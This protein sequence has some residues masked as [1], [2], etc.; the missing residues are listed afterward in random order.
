MPRR[1]K[2][3]GCR[4][5]RGGRPERGWARS[6]ILAPAEKSIHIIKSTAAACAGVAL[7]L[8]FTLA[9]ILDLILTMRLYTAVRTLGRILG[10]TLGR[11]L[12][13]QSS[14]I[15]SGLTVVLSCVH[16]NLI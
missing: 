11:T 7:V 2:G 9:L 12:E 1:A 4:R 15:D 16:L 6:A 14:R 13:K 5:A 8:A 3:W 10:R